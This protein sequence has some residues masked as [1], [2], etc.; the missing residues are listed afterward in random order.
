MRQLGDLAGGGPEGDV[1]ARVREQAGEARQQMAAGD[2]AGA[3]RTLQQSASDLDDLRAMLADEEGLQQAQRDLR[4]SADQ[5]ARGR[6]GTAMV[7]FA[8]PGG[9][10]FS[11]GELSDLLAYIRSLAS[12]RK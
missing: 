3:R 6:P 5:I 9:H 8:G 2:T 11:K 1:P 12:R 10:G 7:A 4:R